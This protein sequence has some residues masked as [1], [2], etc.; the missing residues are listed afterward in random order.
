MVDLSGLWGTEALLGPRLHGRLTLSHSAEKWDAEVAGAEAIG[1]HEGDWLV[2]DFPGGEGELRLKQ[3][4]DSGKL[5]AHWVQ[6]PGIT[7]GFSY[8]TPVTLEPA[9]DGTWQAEVVPLD[10]RLELYMAV[11]QRDDESLGAFIRDPLANVGVFFPIGEVTVHGDTIMLQ[12]S[13]DPGSHINCIYSQENGTLSTRLPFFPVDLTFTRRSREN[14]SGFYPSTAALDK[15]EYR[16]PFPD[17]D[18]WATGSLA[19][20]GFEEAP[21]VELVESILRT[22]TTG[23]ATPYIQGLL[24]ARHG[25]L[26]LEEYFCG[27][28]GDR[29]HD[30]RSATKSLAT[31]LAGIAID[32]GAPL[33]PDMPVLAAFPEYSDVANK[34]AS[35]ERITLK[36]LLTMN[37]GLE[38]D[39]D[40]DESLG[41]EDN[42]QS[43]Q[44]QPDWYKYALDLPVVREPGEKAVYCSAGINLV[45]GMVRR[46][47]KTWLPEFFRNY[48]ASPL[49]FGPYHLQLTP[50][51]DMYLGGGSYMRP[52]DF[53]KFGQLFLSGGM[54]NGKRVISESWVRESMQPHASLHAEND[55]GFGWH[56]TDYHVGER[57]YRA[58]YAAGNG[59]QLLIIVPNCDVVVMLTAANYANYPTW[60]RFRDELVPQQ[61]LTAVKP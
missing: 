30:L 32:R 5:K 40:N 42:M 12:H 18:G 54:W 37:S 19:E 2:F 39:D 8:A 15:Y 21:I 6:P 52:R 51:G 1:Q 53:M 20:E 41:N 43:Q 38:C 49:D 46:A 33:S 22:E 57:A 34:S 11:T 58:A 10:D 44:D 27:F 50:T 17:I 14:A 61:I 59:G 4:P 24:I 60:R 25:R 55:Y 35:N 7:G 28:D 26:V 45:G 31:I 48:V 47:V 29:P 9:G 36:H 16:Q 3:E 23:L 13:N 56:L